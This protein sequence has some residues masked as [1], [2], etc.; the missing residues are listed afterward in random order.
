MAKRILVTFWIPPEVTDS[1]KG[2]FELVYP[3]EEI[4]GKFPLE[5]TLG[6]LPDVDGVLV[7]GEKVDRA[8]IDLG[9]RLAVIGRFGVGCDAVDCEYAG[10]KGIPVINTPQAVTQ[11]T[12]ELSIALM[13]DIARGVARLDRKLR[14]DKRCIEPFSFENTS[15]S[16]HGKTLGIIGFG[17]IGRAVG[18][19]AVGLGMRIIYSDVF[20]APAEVEQRLAAKRVST[21][22]VLKTS[23]FVSIHCQYTPENHHLINAQTLGMMKPAAYLVNASRGKMIDEAALV[24]ALKAKTIKGAAID[25]YEFE[26]EVNADLIE[27]D[28][29]VLTPHIGTWSYDARV[30]MGR[31]AL[32][33]MTA[34]LDGG[35]PPNVFNRDFLPKK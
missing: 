22:E 28:N 31:E 23:D 32:A 3:K 9:K 30:A 10:V 35:N 33:G 20:P 29:V 13:L 19:K 14:R 34:V 27:L 11:P 21:E 6:L 7:G 17:R 26:P 8:F 16:L 25:V 1:V 15:S 4:S 2:N 24:A 12:A 5:E 18:E